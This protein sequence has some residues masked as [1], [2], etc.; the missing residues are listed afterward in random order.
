MKIVKPILMLLLIMP[1]SVMA[2]DIRPPRQPQQTPTRTSE[3]HT[4]SGHGDN[5]EKYG[6]GIVVGIAVCYLFDLKPC[7]KEP[8]PIFKNIKSEPNP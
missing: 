8:E 1:L 5:V 2:T 3:T 4:S 6:A 7:R